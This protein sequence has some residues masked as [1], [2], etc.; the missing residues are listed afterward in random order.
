[1][2]ATTGGSTSGTV[3]RARSTPRPRNVTRA[4]I[5][6][7]GRPSTRQTSIAAVD[8]TMLSHSASRRGSEA[9][10]DGRVAQSVA[11]TIAT[12]GTTSSEDRERGGQHQHQRWASQ[13]VTPP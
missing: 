2:P 8:V 7:T 5:H 10:S 11:A 6:A 3:T 13:R 12:S 9:S 4:R 1:M